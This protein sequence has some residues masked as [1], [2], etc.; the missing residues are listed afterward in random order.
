M[1]NQVAARDVAIELFQRDVTVVLEVL[2]DLHLDVVPREIAAKLLTIVAEFVCYGGE[3]N[4]DGHGL[5]SARRPCLNIFAQRCRDLKAISQ[6]LR[7][8][9]WSLPTRCQ[10]ARVRRDE[11][12]EWLR[13]SVA[14]STRRRRPIAACPTCSRITPARSRSSTG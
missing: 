14:T 5:Q 7:K 13:S 12:Q 8:H 2:L 10:R 4:P 3:K 9:G 11:M 1:D 6:P